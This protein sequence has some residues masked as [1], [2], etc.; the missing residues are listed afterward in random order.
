MQTML[1]PE[2]QPLSNSLPPALD[3]AAN[4]RP[5]FPQ[6]VYP[7]TIHP[8]ISPIWSILPTS[9]IKLMANAILHAQQAIPVIPTTPTSASNAILIV[10]NAST[11]QLHVL[12]VLM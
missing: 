1:S 5:I 7:A 10:Y 4:A 6:T 2:I 11:H 3:P 8:K 9:Q 12:P